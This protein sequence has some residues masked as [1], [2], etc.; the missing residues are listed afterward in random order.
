MKIAE[1]LITL[2]A[3]FGA[4]KL[5]GEIAERLRQPAVLGELIG[6]I[7]VGVSVLGLVDPHDTT[8]HL[9]SEL[10]VILLLFMIGLETDLK[11]LLAVGPASLAVAVVG[12]ALPFLFG[13]LVGQWLGYAPVLSIF[14]GAALTATSV[15]ITARVLSDLGHLQTRESQVVLGAA[16]LDDI[17]GLVILTIVSALAAGATLTVGS[18]ARTTIVAFGF[19]VL[20]IV[21][22]GFLVRYL[23]AVIAR[24]RVAGALS[25]SAMM[26]AFI[27][28]YLAEA[29]GS[30]LIVGAFAAGLVLARTEKARQIE[31]EVHDVAQ[32]FVPIFFIS[33]GAA[34]DLKSLNPFDPASREFL[35]IGLVLALVGIVGKVLAGYVAIGKGL[36]RLVIGV[37]M[38]PRG[39]VGLIFAQIGLAAGLLSAGLYSSVAL[40][41]MITTFVGPLLLRMLLPKGTPQEFTALAG[42]VTEAPY[43]DDLSGNS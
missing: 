41:V 33:V 9:L 2:V 32:F 35:I 7:V 16:V 43:D 18:V 29:A 39:E 42:I 27:L 23:I 8:I 20:A 30:A 4:A 5:F 1:F 17:I 12:V 34:V 14:L 22:G 36:R 31:R 24:L 11:K 15:G 26:F 10:G 28:A 3:I 6:G 13:Y 40:M 37:G 38:I 25:F 21:V 19:V